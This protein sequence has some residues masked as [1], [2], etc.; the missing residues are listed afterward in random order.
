MS[1]HTAREE[2][3]EC[4]AALAD[5]LLDSQGRWV[6]ESL[7]DVLLAALQSGGF[8]AHGDPEALRRVAG[9]LAAVTL[10]ARRRRVHEP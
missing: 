9:E 3:F 5:A 10:D 1:E 7:R 6:W 8:D 2:V 4:A